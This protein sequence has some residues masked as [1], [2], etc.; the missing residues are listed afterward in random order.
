MRTKG[1]IRTIRRNIPEV[2]SFVKFLLRAAFCHELDERSRKTEK[3]KRKKKEVSRQTSR[4]HRLRRSSSTSNEESKER[5][6]F[7]PFQSQMA[8]KR[9]MD[10]VSDILPN[11]PEKKSLY[12]YVADQ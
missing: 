11:T 6:Q 9:T 2:I 10:A 1:T 3:I 7:L 8:K 4:R 5:S 12:Y